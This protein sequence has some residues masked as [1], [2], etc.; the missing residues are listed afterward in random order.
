[1]LNYKLLNILFFPIFVVLILLNYLGLIS[2]LPWLILIIFYLAVLIIGS[3]RIQLNFYFNSLNS[4]VADKKEIALTFDDGP[5]PEITLKVLEILK[6]HQVKAAFF[7]IGKQTEK[8]PGITKATFKNGH[9]I[10]NHSYTHNSFF[11]F[12]SATKMAGEM[13]K[14]TNIILQTT[15]HKPLLFRPPF[16]VTNPLLK[17]ALNRT[18]LI[19]VGWSVRSMD[20]VKTPGKVLEKLKKQ[21]H[22]GAVILLHDTHEK[23]IPILDGFLPWLQEN[24]YR[25]SGLDELLKIQA[26]ELD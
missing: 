7:C 23:I 20:T 6:K 16:G 13:N 17:K 11:D 22:P 25:I 9:I 21:T 12:F 24:G 3:S 1:M 10:G 4:G 15:G 2:F 18:K 19:P 8:H 26:Y 14:T 5:H